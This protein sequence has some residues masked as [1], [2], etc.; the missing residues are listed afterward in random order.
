MTCSKSQETGVR[1]GRAW[2]AVS[3]IQ[4]RDPGRTLYKMGSKEFPEEM[5]AFWQSPLIPARPGLLPQD[6]PCPLQKEAVPISPP[7]RL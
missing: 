3:D 6:H 7:Q 1:S 5:L 2:A 4:K